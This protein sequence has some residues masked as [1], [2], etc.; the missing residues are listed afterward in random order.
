MLKSQHTCPALKGASEFVQSL[1]EKCYVPS[2]EARTYRTALNILHIL[3]VK[4]DRKRTLTYQIKRYSETLYVYPIISASTIYSISSHITSH[5]K[6]SPAISLPTLSTAPL[7]SGPH[8]LFNGDFVLE[9]LVPPPSLHATVLL[10]STF[11][12]RAGEKGRRHALCPP[13]HLHF[14]QEEGFWVVRGVLGCV[15]GWKGNRDGER[16]VGV[17]LGV[18]V[19]FEWMDL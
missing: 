1:L 15:E 16:G 8:T 11:L 6:M 14:E 13:M 12:R 17:G 4:L 7:L 9:I 2:S 5:H 3:W 18:Q 19:C 10:R